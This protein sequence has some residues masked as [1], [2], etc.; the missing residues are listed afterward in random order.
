M[1]EMADANIILFKQPPRM[2]DTQGRP[3]PTRI[4]YIIDD[5]FCFGAFVVSRESALY[6]CA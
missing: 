5:L 4:Q 1:N 6:K 3:R 2:V